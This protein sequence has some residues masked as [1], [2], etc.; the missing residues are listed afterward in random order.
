MPMSEGEVHDDVS[1]LTALLLRAGPLVLAAVVGALVLD[2]GFVYDD[3][4]ALLENPVPPPFPAL[5]QELV[6][7]TTQAYTIGSVRRG[8]SQK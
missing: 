6:A 2:G 7:P 5:C 3:P 4:S 1:R 8:G